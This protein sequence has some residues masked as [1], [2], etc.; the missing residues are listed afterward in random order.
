MFNRLYWIILRLGIYPSS[1]HETKWTDYTD[2]YG[3][4]TVKYPSKWVIQTEAVRSPRF[5]GDVPFQVC[6]T[7]NGIINQ[8]VLVKGIP[9][10]VG[11]DAR[12]VATNIQND[13]QTYYGPAQVVDPIACGDRN[14]AKTCQYAVLVGYGLSQSKWEVVSYVDAAQGV[15]S[16]IY[17]I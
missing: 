17:C 10:S 16:F 8:C 9:N 3:R 2:P 14:G 11:F 5:L 12:E 15:C 7:H 6:G 13:L 4:Y 1:T